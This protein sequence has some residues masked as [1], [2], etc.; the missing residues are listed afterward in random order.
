MEFGC[1]TILS[2]QKVAT[3]EA[4]Q[5]PK[6]PKSKSTGGFINK[7]GHPVSILI[8]ILGVAAGYRGRFFAKI[9]DTLLEKQKEV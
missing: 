2:G 6:L 3:V 9:S 5:L 7:M 1:S 8:N 4:H